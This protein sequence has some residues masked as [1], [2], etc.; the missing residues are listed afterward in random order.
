[1]MKMAKVTITLVEVNETFKDKGV[2]PGVR[3]SIAFD[4]PV[5]MV[6]T[7]EEEKRFDEHR[8][9][10]SVAQMIDKAASMIADPI[11]GSATGTVVVKGSDEELPINGADKATKANFDKADRMKGKTFFFPRDFDP[12]EV[13]GWMIQDTLDRARGAV[14][15]AENEADPAEALGTAR[16]PVEA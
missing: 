3:Y 13:L 4:P 5:V 2:V 7:E 9:L 11:R 16:P 6:E 14:N 10:W 12:A 1:M 8:Q 15:N